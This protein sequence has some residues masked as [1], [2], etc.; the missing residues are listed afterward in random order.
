MR[1]EKLIGINGGVNKKPA[2]L[3]VPV[4]LEHVDPVRGYLDFVIFL[5]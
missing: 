5:Q 2:M 4:H 3:L 1:Q